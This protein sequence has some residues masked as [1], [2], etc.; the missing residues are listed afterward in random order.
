MYSPRYAWS[1]FQTNVPT[2]M[3]GVH[4]STRGVRRSRNI[5]FTRTVK[6]KHSH[7]NVSAVSYIRSA[8]AAHK[9]TWCPRM[10]VNKHK[11]PTARLLFVLIPFQVQA[12]KS[13]ELPTVDCRSFVFH[14]TIRLFTVRLWDKITV[15]LNTFR[16]EC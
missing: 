13:K 14:S 16:Y 6:T 2:R 15:E 10:Y 12:R 3:R 4:T 7:E 5:Q 9:C 8:I 11:R 1:L